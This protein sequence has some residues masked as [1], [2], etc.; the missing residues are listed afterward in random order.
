M[1]SHAYI[2]ACTCVHVKLS[3]KNIYHTCNTLHIYT[4]P[5]AEFSNTFNLPKFLAYKLISFDILLVISHQ[6]QA[7]GIYLKCMQ[8]EASVLFICY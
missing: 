1:D 8:I 4:P 3:N 5:K 6:L 7:A 2:A